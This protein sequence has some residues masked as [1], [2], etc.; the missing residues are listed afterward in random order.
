MEL[1]LRPDGQGTWKIFKCIYSH[2]RT[3]EP[4]KKKK[5]GYGITLTQEELVERPDV[6]LV[7]SGANLIQTSLKSGSATDITHI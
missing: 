1:L 5:N 4:E 6:R 7:C 2:M 3:C